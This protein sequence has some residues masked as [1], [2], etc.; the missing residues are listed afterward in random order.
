MHKP[1]MRRAGYVNDTPYVQNQESSISMACSAAVLLVVGFCKDMMGLLPFLHVTPCHTHHHSHTVHIRN[2]HTCHTGRRN[3]PHTLQ[4]RQ[5]SLKHPLCH[6]YP[7]NHRSRHIRILRI[8]LLL[9]LLHLLLLQLPYLGLLL[10]HQHQASTCF[11]P[12]TYLDFSSSIAPPT[13]STISSLRC[14]NQ[15]FCLYAAIHLSSYNSHTKHQYSVDIVFDP[16][17][18]PPR[19]SSFLLLLLPL[20]FFCYAA[21][22]LSSYHSHTKHHQ[23]SDL[24]FDPPPPPGLPT[25]HLRRIYRQQSRGPRSTCIIEVPN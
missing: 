16:P 8:L 21:S 14:G 15:L 25:L 17:P 13:Y 19:L 22:H 24:L 1:K 2:H 9:L 5:H 11:R 4:R 3:R 6:I 20:L 23:Y 7:H 10:Q 12:Y 18:P